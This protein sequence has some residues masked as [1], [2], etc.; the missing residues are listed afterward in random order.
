MELVFAVI[1][2]AGVVFF[3]VLAARSSYWSKTPMMTLDDDEKNRR[4]SR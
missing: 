1:G 3:G 4:N 2:V